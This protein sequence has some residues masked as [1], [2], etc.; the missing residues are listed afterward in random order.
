MSY[1]VTGVEGAI[2]QGD[3]LKPIKIKDWLPWWPDERLH[4]V[5]VMTPTCDLA[6]DK[7]DYHRLCVMQ[8]FALFLYAIGQ[9]LNL[10]DSHW[11]GEEPLSKGKAGDL[12]NRL[13]T[14]VTN[15]WPRFHF[16][17]SQPGIFTSDRFID[18]E[19]VLT[20]PRSAI[21]LE[22]RHARYVSPY[23]EELIHRYAHHVMRIGTEDVGDATI[24]RAID[25]CVSATPLVLPS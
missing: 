12:R 14:A 18:F 7:A 17:P 5:V 16:V 21:T 20:L 24:G 15:S 10:S 23:R 6:Q 3:I 1:Y 4:P 11:K 22:H 25:A 2:D 9:L 13:K 19:V 8:P